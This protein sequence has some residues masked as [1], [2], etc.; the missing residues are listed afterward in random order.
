M[1]RRAIPAALLAPLL[2]VAIVVSSS[3]C[4][5]LANFGAL[6]IQNVPSS[7][8]PGRVHPVPV[9]YGGV[10]W[11]IER[12]IDSELPIENKVLISPL[13]LVDL[14]LS[15]TLDT[16]TLPIVCWLNVRTAWNQ[17]FV[18]AAGPLRVRIVDIQPAHESSM[19]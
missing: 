9:P 19:P 5:T 4:G 17:A 15:A 1:N 16:A 7:E 14:G 10:Y 13:W 8:N 2:I 3:A 6:P 11:D 12:A 18:D